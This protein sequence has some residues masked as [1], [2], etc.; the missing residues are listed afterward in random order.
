MPDS[1]PAKRQERE[2]ERRMN[3]EEYIERRRKN[4]RKKRIYGKPPVII[5][6]T[7]ITT[8]G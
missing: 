7:Q 4:Y 3:R 6:R 2:R 1:R 8:S 5:Y